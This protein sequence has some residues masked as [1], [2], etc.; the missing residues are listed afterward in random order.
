MS[1]REQPETVGSAIVDEN[2][3]RSLRGIFEAHAYAIS[4]KS[5]RV[6]VQVGNLQG[7]VDADMRHAA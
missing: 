7:V 2:R 6:S 3:Y 5:A 4:D 1:T